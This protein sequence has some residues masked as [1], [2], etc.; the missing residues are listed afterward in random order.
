M[1]SRVFD[2][3]ANGIENVTK[4]WCYCSHDIETKELYQTAIMSGNFSE[5]ILIDWM[6]VDLLIGHNIK[7]Y[8]LPVLEEVLGVTYKG[9]IFDTLLMSQLLKNDRPGGHSLAAWAKRLGMEKQEHD[10]WDRYSPEMLERC[11]TDVEIN[12][13][14]YQALLKEMEI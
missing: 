1:I 12:V 14:I 5:N 9:E 11:K 13:A 7:R 8:D 2:I 4:V 10:E 3:E 6:G